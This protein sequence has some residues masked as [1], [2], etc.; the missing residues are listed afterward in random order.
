MVVMHHETTSP[1]REPSMISHIARGTIGALI[2]AVTGLAT[3]CIVGMLAWDAVVGPNWAI[4]GAAMGA[5]VG[6]LL[7]GFGDGPVRSL[8]GGVGG[9]GGGFFAIAAAEQSPP[10]SAEWA[11][12][13][14][15]LGAGL[16]VPIVVLTGIA[17]GVM[18]T[19][20]RPRA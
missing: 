4:I 16:S 3:V 7:R 8:A 17:V 20:V 19:V 9:A 12:R 10:G 11:V 13:G 18:L 2:A 15:L 14:G 1:P 6:G 5:L